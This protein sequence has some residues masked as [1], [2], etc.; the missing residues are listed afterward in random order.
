MLE[1]NRRRGSFATLL[2]LLEAR[3]TSSE[4]V[5]WDPAQWIAYSVLTCTSSLYDRQP[6]PTNEVLS[7]EGAQQSD[8]GDGPAAYTVGT[9]RLQRR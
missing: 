1:E 8:R 2:T 9:R 6:P 3:W 7:V 4:P 5:V